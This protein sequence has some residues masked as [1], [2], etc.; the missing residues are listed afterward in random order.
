MLRHRED[1][2]KMNLKEIRCEGVDS[3][4]LAQDGDQWRGIS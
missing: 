4:E 1:D 3:T 2:I